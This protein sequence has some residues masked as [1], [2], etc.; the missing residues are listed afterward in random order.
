M[1][2]KSTIK[3]KMK[4]QTAV[5]SVVFCHLVDIMAKRG[6][7]TAVGDDHFKNVL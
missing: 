4:Q 3:F 5:K 7:K 2:M 1:Q 6:D